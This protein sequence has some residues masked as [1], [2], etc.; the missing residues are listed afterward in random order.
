MA[1]AGAGAGIVAESSQLAGEAFMHIAMFELNPP[2]CWGWEGTKC[3][4][5]MSYNKFQYSGDPH[6][7]SGS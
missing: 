3:D 7:I 5:Q 6:H 2:L 1:G 4:K